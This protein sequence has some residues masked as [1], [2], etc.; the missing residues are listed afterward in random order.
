[1]ESAPA[2]VCGALPCLEETAVLKTLENLRNA[3]DYIV[4]VGSMAPTE[5]PHPLAAFLPHADRI[6]DG[7]GV[8]VKTDMLED[9]FTL[10]FPRIRARFV[11]VTAGWSWPTP[12]PHRRHL[13]D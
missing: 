13:E 3:C 11:L 7:S 8:F 1:M 2:T 12:G 5:R 10:A 6:P 9:F 4:Q